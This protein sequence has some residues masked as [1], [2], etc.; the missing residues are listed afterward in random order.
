MPNERVT[1][2]LPDG[3]SMGAY[4]A[5][6]DSPGPHPSVIVWMEILGVNA[7]IQSVA[8]RVAGHGLKEALERCAI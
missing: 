4:V 1:I 3:A 6:P 7:H 8:D 2:Q 5:T